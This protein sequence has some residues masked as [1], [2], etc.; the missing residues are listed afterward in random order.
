MSKRSSVPV[1]PTHQSNSTTSLSSQEKP[2]GEK[3]IVIRKWALSE[4]ENVILPQLLAIK[5]KMETAP[6]LDEAKPIAQR[7]RDLKEVIY[8]E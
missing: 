2:L 3:V 8:L 6:S 1:Q 5:Q 4:I 7:L